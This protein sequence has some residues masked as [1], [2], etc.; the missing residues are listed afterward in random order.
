MLPGLDIQPED[1]PSI[2]Q[3]FNADGTLNSTSAP[4]TKFTLSS[5]FSP[6]ILTE[7]VGVFVRPLTVRPFTWELMV[8]ANAVQGLVDGKRIITDVVPSL[9]DG[10]TT[11]NVMTLENFFQV[12]IGL[13]NSFWGVLFDHFTYSGSL[14][15]Y[16]AFYD[17]GSVV[18]LSNTF[19]N[20]ISMDASLGVTYQPL[21]WLGFSWEGHAK[22]QPY[23]TTEF[24]L[25]SFLNLNF[26]L[27]M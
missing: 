10:P 5:V 19:A 16:Y 6:M 21:S 1:S 20:N 27:S 18:D 24:Q 15:V 7:N 13:G 9:G 8:G 3:V 14:N 22:Y 23:V 12:G 17:S 4:L 2:Y 26:S 11:T 25:D